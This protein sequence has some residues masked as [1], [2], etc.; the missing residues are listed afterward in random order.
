M[1]LKSLFAGG[2]ERDTWKVVVQEPR[3][4]TGAMLE[5]VTES[6]ELECS[7]NGGEWPLI[8]GDQQGG[9]LGLQ[10]DGM[11]VKGEAFLGE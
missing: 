1:E 11:K 7:R 4:R 2:S 9:G 10:S 6:Q 3:I 8:S 5:K